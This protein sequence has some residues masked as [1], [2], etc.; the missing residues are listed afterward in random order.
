M[1]H[2]YV[3]IVELDGETLVKLLLFVN[4]ITPKHLLGKRKE[5][6]NRKKKKL[7]LQ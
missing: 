4:R 7:S 1:L 3:E 6:L 5:H 2:V